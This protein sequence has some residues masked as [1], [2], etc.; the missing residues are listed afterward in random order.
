[1]AS[2]HE[3][4]ITHAM[5]PAE[6]LPAPQAS[7]LPGFGPGFVHIRQ[8]QIVSVNVPGAAAPPRGVR[9]LNA[10]GCILLPGL[11][12]VHV[13]G[14]MGHDT[15]DATPEA[16]AAMARFFAA[17]GVTAFLATTMTASAEATLAAVRAAADYCRGPQEP[18]GARLLGVH[19]EG[20]FISPEFPGAQRADQI[21]PPDLAEFDALCQAG[22][23]RMIT[24]APEQP[25]AKA[26]IAAARRRQ[27]V[28]VAGHTSATYEE[29]LAGI[30]AGITQA[31]H[32]YNAMTGLHH[33]RPGT[34][35]AVLSDDRVYAQLIADN[36]HV[37]PA[38][39]KILARCKG[40]SR[41][42]LIT[43]AMRAAGLPPGQYDLGGQMVTVQ[44]NQC[45][46][47]DGTLAGSVLTL[48]RG[49]A[50]FTAASGLDL[51]QSW[52]AASRTPA[53]SL[54]LDHELGAIAVGY[55]ADL[56]LLDGELN[57]VAT[58]VDGQ[59]AYLQDEARLE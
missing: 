14:A 49:L 36:I 52:P 59:V 12:D 41:T 8:G 11:I 20:P 37:H 5:V 27:I 54:G 23:V 38:A 42:V 57:V 47:A 21:R 28:A 15:M 34:L 55:R 6:F 1:M 22:P 30:E 46:L 10:E 29:C 44:D 3:L 32:T 18:G 35:G 25:G 51:A 19:L 40:P 43:D 9:R 48:E 2:N 53:Q 7:S 26:L 16:L 50:H 17:H 31:T 58:L 24:L 33:R 39:M 45:R 56:V 4:F 13:H